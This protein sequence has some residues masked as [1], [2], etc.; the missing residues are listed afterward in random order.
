M[1][2]AGAEA[3]SFELPGATQDDRDQYRLEDH[4]SEGAAVLSFYPFDFSPVC[5]TQL[6][7]LR[8][9]EWLEFDENINVFGISADSAYAH[10]K[11]AQEH[12]LPFPLLSDYS[13]DV[14]DEFGVLQDEQEGHRD[15]PKRSVFVVDSDQEV[16][17]SWLR[18]VPT[19]TPDMNELLDG[20]RSIAN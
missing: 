5:T 14:A 15:V 12:S 6:C 17:Y 20:V 4:I 1:L 3:P 9:I 8:D 18:S 13:A 2:D 16:R 7:D 19:E 10:Q 11:F